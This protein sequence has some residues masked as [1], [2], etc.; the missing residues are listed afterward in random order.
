PMPKIIDFGIAKALFAS[1]DDHHGTR[2]DAGRVIGTPGYM[3]PEQA[4]GQSSAI[5]ERADVFALGVML[6]ELLTG[7]LPWARGAAATD[8]EPVRPS[9][10]VTTSSS[11]ASSSPPTQ[12]RQ[13]AAEL[14]GDLDWITL[15]ALARE[16]DER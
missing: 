2:T 16:R 1:D 10:R 15:K 4:A 3:S 12:R 9:V 7:E 8:S 14:R 13:L 6:Y 5:D 11:A